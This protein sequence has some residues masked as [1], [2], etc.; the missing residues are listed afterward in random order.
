MASAISH[1]TGVSMRLFV[2]L[3]FWRGDLVDLP[4]VI[5]GKGR[6]IAVDA[7]FVI[8]VEGWSWHVVRTK[9]FLS[10]KVHRRPTL[11]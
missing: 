9:T 3:H 5:F 8:S 10:P 6:S 1:F 2:F 11:N 4:K 7:L